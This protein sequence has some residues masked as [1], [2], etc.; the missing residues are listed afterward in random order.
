MS[1]RHLAFAAIPVALALAALIAGSG[2]LAAQEDAAVVAPPPALDDPTIVAI[3]DNANTFDI[4][5]GRLAENL[6]KRLATR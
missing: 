6:G 4:E 2:S 1:K 3:F 5:T